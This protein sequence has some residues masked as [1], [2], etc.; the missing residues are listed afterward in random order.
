MLIGVS[1]ETL[2]EQFVT[3]QQQPVQALVLYQTRSGGLTFLEY[4]FTVQQ[5]EEEQKIFYTVNEAQ[6]GFL[7]PALKQPT[8]WSYWSCNGYQTLESMTAVGGIQPMW[9]HLL[10]AGDL[11]MMFGGGDQL[12]MDGIIKLANTSGT[13]NEGLFATPLLAEWLKLPIPERKV[14]PFTPQ[15]C[16]QVYNFALQQYIEHFNEPEFRTALAT[17]P[18]VMSWDDHDCWDGVGSYPDFNDSPVCRK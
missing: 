8:R 18:S 1:N 7:V 4:N 10:S 5:S 13:H 11:H 2:T 15:M 14:A 12:Y 16:E 6:F 17:I 9:K 3:L